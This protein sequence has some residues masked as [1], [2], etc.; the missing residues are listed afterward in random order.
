MT[1]L[2]PTPRRLQLVCVM[3]AITQLTC[4][5]WQVVDMGKIDRAA[6]TQNLAL[7]FVGYWLVFGWGVAIGLHR[8]ISHRR[9][10]HNSI[11]MWICTYFGTLAVLGRPMEWAIVHRVHH[12]FSDSPDDPHSPQHAGFWRVFLNTWTLSPAQQRHLAKPSL[13]RDL[14]S[15][16]PIQFFQVYYWPTIF[17]TWSIILLVGGYSAWISLAAWPAALSLLNT[18]IVNALTHRQGEV[19][20][21]PALGLLTLGET[22]H[23]AHHLE[24]SRQ[25]YSGQGRLDLTGMTL[26]FGQKI[27]NLSR[28]LTSRRSTQEL[29]PDRSDAPDLGRNSIDTSHRQIPH[30]PHSL[31]KEVIS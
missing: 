4:G 9:L 2:T 14:V 3:A 16:R 30:L 23:R 27:M 28:G 15:S 13:A 24:P 10:N 19:R 8:G 29:A 7:V 12:Q 1:R 26:D 21:L 22:Y 5:V 20:D 17:V 6:L 18:S 31:R 25:N 11:A